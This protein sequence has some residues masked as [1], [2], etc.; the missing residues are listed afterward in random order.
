MRVRSVRHRE[1]L[2]RVALFKTRRRLASGRWVLVRAEIVGVDA[3][4]WRL[5]LATARRSAWR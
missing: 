5:V 4:P 1:R 3:P 2:A